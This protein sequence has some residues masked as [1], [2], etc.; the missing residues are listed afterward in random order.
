MTGSA[1]KTCKIFDLRTGT[2][3]NIKPA[4]T[5]QATDAVFCGEIVADSNL[6][7]AGCGDGNILAFDIDKNGECVYG[8]GADNVGALHC[9]RVTPDKKALITGGDSGQALKINFGGF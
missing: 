3:Q 6:L 8:Y 7:I 1:D 5:M 2:G 4:V 9:L